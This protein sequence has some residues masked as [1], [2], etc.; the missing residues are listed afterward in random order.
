MSKRT[1]LILNN[2]L[3]L[4]ENNQSYKMEQKRLQ[5]NECNAELCGTDQQP[6]ICDEPTGVDLPVTKSSHSKK[7][8][9]LDQAHQKI[10]DEYSDD[11]LKDR[12]F[13]PDAESSSN[14]EEDEDDLLL[15]D[16]KEIE[17]KQKLMQ[18]K[19]AWKGRSKE[20]RHTKYPGQ[21]F[22]TRKKLKDSNKTHYSVK[23][24]LKGTKQF[25]DY[26]CRCL[27]KCS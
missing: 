19:E 24:K 9:F 5:L 16:K 6:Q 8:R 22:A 3:R 23:G 4:M 18:E 13:V 10:E 27:K 11:S 2:A 21:T 25:Y 14:S 17:I 1:K 26:K 15:F 20:G 7:F 12:D